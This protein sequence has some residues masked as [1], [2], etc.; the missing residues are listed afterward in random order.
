MVK[1][2][3]IKGK[4]KFSKTKNEDSDDEDIEFGGGD[5]KKSEGQQTAEED[6]QID[7]EDVDDKLED[8]DYDDMDDDDEDP[9]EDEDDGGD[10]PAGGE[11]DDC[12][13]NTGKRGKKFGKILSN[14]DKDDEDD[15]EFEDVEIVN[16]SVL[17]PMIY[18]EP[19]ERISGKNLTKYEFV[20]LIGDRT[21]QLTLGAKPMIKNVAHMNPRDIAQ[22]E[23]EAKL[24]PINIIRP[25]PNG[26]KERWNLSELNL[27]KEFIRFGTNNISSG[28]QLVKKIPEV[29]KNVEKKSI[30]K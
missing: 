30:K 26:R 8:G 20:R 10:E 7:D 19:N 2:K 25:L 6:I 14:I 5:V 27:R 1:G 13:Y 9:H 21:T 4:V 28:E 11:D 15:D 18:V 3:N 24:I 16:E 29:K 17:N 23:L 22:L 12:V